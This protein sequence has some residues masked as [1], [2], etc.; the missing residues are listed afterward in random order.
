MPIEVIASGTAFS[1]IH[2]PE[3][4]NFRLVESEVSLGAK[5]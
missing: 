5:T 3:K 2:L 1:S 4:A